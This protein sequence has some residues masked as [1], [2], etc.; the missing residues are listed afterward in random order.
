LSC[1]FHAKN[2]QIT[3]VFHRILGGQL[4]PD[5]PNKTKGFEVFFQNVTKTGVKKNIADLLFALQ[6]E[7]DEL[8]VAR[9]KD[10]VPEFRSN[11][12]VFSSLDKVTG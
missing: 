10:M 8:L 2:T 6:I 9:M 4:S 5:Y 12:S 7:N 3:G 1:F 11:N